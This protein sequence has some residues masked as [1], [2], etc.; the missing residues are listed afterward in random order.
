LNK[1]KQFPKKEGF[2]QPF[3]V[4]LDGYQKITKKIN[5]FSYFLHYLSN[6][7]HTAITAL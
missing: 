5:I 6:Y 7:C 2:Y 4:I 3:V 1:I